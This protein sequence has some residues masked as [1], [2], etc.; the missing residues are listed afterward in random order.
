LN[1]SKE[2]LI[3]NDVATYTEDGKHFWNLA[4]RTDAG[5]TKEDLWQESILY[6]EDKDH[7][8]ALL[9]KLDEEEMIYS[10]EEYGDGKYKISITY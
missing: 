8:D 6:I 1:G 10:L 2:P 7:K 3:H 4:I 5:Y 9:N